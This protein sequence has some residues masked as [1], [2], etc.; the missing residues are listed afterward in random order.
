M[1]PLFEVGIAVVVVVAVRVAGESQRARVTSQIWPA[2][3]VILAVDNFSRAVFD[4]IDDAVVYT[5]GRAPTLAR[6]SSSTSRTS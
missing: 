2:A 3:Y 4:I 5:A 1:E 6:T